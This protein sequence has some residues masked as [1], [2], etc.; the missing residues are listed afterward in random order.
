MAAYF[1]EEIE[2]CFD[3]NFNFLPVLLVWVCVMPSEHGKKVNFISWLK[4]GL[5]NRFIRHFRL[6][7]LNWVVL[8]LSAPCHSRWY[9]LKHKQKKE[10]KVL[11]I[12]QK[13]TAKFYI[14][15]CTTN[16]ENFVHNSKCF[17]ADSRELLFSHQ[18]LSR[19]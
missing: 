10:R 1:M 5:Y 17:M 12:L 18:N 16:N 14:L 3:H 11:T 4:V 15:H 19:V 7:T 6:F 2:Y 13:I 8:A 9:L